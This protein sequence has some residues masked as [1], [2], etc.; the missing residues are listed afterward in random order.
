MKHKHCD[1]I[2]AWA[3]GAE[4]EYFHTG[5]QQWFKAPSPQWNEDTEYRIKPKEEFLKYKVALFKFP[6]GEFYTVT[7]K[8]EA[9]IIAE[10][11]EEFVMWLTD[12][13]TV[14]IGCL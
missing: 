6:D 3:D 14:N 7:Y 5:C 10:Q 12:E 13:Q 11:F 9:Y 4:I 2:K 8:S 1:I